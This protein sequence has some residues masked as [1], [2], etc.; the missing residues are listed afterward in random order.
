[1]QRKDLRKQTFGAT[2]GGS[3][4]ICWHPILF[5]PLLIAQGATYEGGIYW[6]GPNGKWNGREPDQG[7]A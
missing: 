3:I 6:I 7:G 1:L 2:Y 5:K 4:S